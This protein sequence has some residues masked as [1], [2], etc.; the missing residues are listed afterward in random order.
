MFYADAGDQMIV[1]AL[2]LDVVL[3]VRLCAAV[4]RFVLAPKRTDLRLVSTDDA[5]AQF[6]YRHLVNIAGVIGVGLF[7]YA[8]MEPGNSQAAG[9]FRFWVGVG[10]TLWFMHFTWRARNGLTDII[11][12]E[13]ENLTPGL[14][15]MAAWWPRVAVVLMAV[16]W[17]SMQFI[18][19]TGNKTLTPGR[20][21]LSLV[22][23]VIA[24]FL[25]TMIRGIATHLVPPM[26]G[27]GPVAEKVYQDT[28]LSYVRI[29]RLILFATL[30]LVLGKLWG[31]N[32]RDWAE[33]GL[34]TEIAAGIVGFLLIF[35]AGYLAWEITNLWINR[36]LVQ[37]MPEPS[38]EQEGGEAG[39]AGL[40]RI[41]TVLPILRMTL[42]AAIV[43]ITMLL[44]LSQ[45]G[46]NI[47]PLLAGAGVLGLA[48]GFGAQTLVKDVVSG[49]FFLLDDA[50]RLG[51]YVDV[52]GTE[53]TVEKISVRSL[54]LRGSTGPVHVVPYGSM[55]KLTNMSRDWVIMKLKFTV[56]FDTDLEKVRKI[57]K[58][59][60]Q[61]IQEVP[62]YAEELLSPFKSQGAAD[63]TDVGIVVRGKFTTKPGGQWAIRKEIYTRVQKA[64]EEN[65]IEFAR[66]EVR[67]QM[68]GH[69]E[70]TDFSAEQKKV[71]AAATSQ[72]A[73]TP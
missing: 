46:V 2:I 58:K 44:A 51:E 61:Q 23:I 66:K 41:A 4:L 47:A 27:E 62:E 55:S 31:L 35:A 5:T 16:D 1:M 30:I 24:P 39:G 43:T 17:L 40:S 10:V 20:S 37:E 69:E 53:G 28:R 18:L 32:L 8:L 50:F 29:G 73:E 36:R 12:G 54:Q 21:A 14:E 71:V 15:K 70:D 68:P 6:L 56:P 49:V 38:V 34:G 63:V 33:T 13:D 11:K 26:Q 67:V 48:I 65:G 72:A 25:D 64:F 22:F 9:T 52:G 59:I 45:L 60:G 57:F 42:Q 3:I 19:S 7:L